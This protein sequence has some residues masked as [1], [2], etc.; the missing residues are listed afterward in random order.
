MDSLLDSYPKMHTVV[1][2]DGSTDGMSEIANA[3]ARQRSDITVVTMPQRGGKSSALN[4]ALPFTTAEILVC[5]DSDSHLG[6]SAIW[7]V[8]QP[9]TDPRVGAVGP[10]VTK[11]IADAFGFPFVSSR[12]PANPAAQPA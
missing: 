6:E 7:E 9:F 1:I 12:L 10:S 11:R 2:D 3:R 5:V 4:A 8:V